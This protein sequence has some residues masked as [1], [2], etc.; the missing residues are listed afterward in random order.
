[1]TA[2]IIIGID[3]DNTIALYDAAFRSAALASGFIG[4]DFQGDR[5]SL[6][7]LV[8]KSPAGEAKWMA[9]QGYVYGAGIGGAQVSPGFVDFARRMNAKAHRLVVISHKTK[10]GHFDAAGIDLRAAATQWMKDNRLLDHPEEVLSSDG[11]YFEET[12]ERKVG[13]IADLAPAAHVDDLIEVFEEPHYPK[14]TRGILL[15]SVSRALPT[16]VTACRTWDDVETQ[17]ASATAA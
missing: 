14:S 17:I 11:I 13:R 3:F 4:N 2:S 16:Y 15:A 12:R 10:Y 9:M 1:V 8:R 6:R 7:D 5:L